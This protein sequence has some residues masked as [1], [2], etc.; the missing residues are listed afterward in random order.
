MLRSLGQ[1]LGNKVGSI[2]QSAAELSTKT[3][4]APHCRTA[5]AVATNVNVDTNTSSPG[6]TPANNNAR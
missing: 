5:L 2:F 3:G 1:F 6:V 4:V